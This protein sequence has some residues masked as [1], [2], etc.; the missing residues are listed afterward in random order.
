MWESCIYKM[1][2][3]TWR[4]GPSASPIFP[5]QR[6]ILPFHD[7]QLIGGSRLRDTRLTFGQF[8]QTWPRRTPS[9]ARSQSG[10]ARAAETLRQ[11]LAYVSAVLLSNSNATNGSS[12]TTQAS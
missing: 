5:V 7:H 9:S 6:G 3:L 4:Y 8:R 1:P 10:T 12:P 2:F 11:P